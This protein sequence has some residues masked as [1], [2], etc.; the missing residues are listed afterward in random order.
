MDLQEFAKS[1]LLGTAIADATLSRTSENGNARIRIGHSIDKSEYLMWK[2]KHISKIV[3][4]TNFG[5]IQGGVYKKSPND[6]VHIN[7]RRDPIVTF[8]YELVYKHGRKTISNELLNLIDD[9]ALSV[10]F[11]DDGSYD[12]HRDN[13]SYW[14]H[15][16]SFPR[17]ENELLATWLE[18][19]YGLSPRLQHIKRND[20]WAIRFPKKDSLVIEGIIAPVV[21]EVSCM[22]YKLASEHELISGVR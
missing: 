18:R 21:S 9:V 5:V 17:S 16:N 8:Y 3:K 12:K 6:Y 13:Q 2:Y 1:V 4:M 20:R 10:W 22:H 7:S 19:K 14:L 11:M 15:T